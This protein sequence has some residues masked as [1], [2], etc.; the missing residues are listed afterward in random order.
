[1]HLRRLLALATASLALAA[2]LAQ[3]TRAQVPAS[4]RAIDERTGAA[5]DLT[6]DYGEYDAVQVYD[7]LEGFNRAIFKFNDVTYTH[8]LRPAV[9][10]YE[11]VVRPP[12]NRAIGNFYDNVRYPVRL[13]NCLLQGKF[14][15]AGLETK[16]FAVNTIGGLGGFI[17]QSD[18]T[19]ELAE[20]PREDL[21]QTL[22]FYGVPHGPYIVIP[23]FGGLSVRDLAGRVGDTVVSP[24]GWE[25]IRLGNH[26]WAGELPWEWQTAITVTD[27]M[28]G[29]P[30]VLDLYTQM[31]SAAVD[32][33]V[34][35]RDGTRR[36]RDAE[37]A[38]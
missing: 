20:L 30:E 5:P 32:P 1:M 37:T 34:S 27:T 14:E 24:T 4:G 9:K 21:G 18:K 29:L 22:G 38:R 31:K 35:L 8:V 23:I 36:Y 11:W 28:S 12:I 7:P 17:R 6:D 3:T 16:K 19:P 15:R 13:V 26:E 33:Y 2:T 10:G 25:Y